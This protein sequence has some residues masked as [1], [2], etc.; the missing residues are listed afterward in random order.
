[1]DTK[2]RRRE[3]EMKGGE[4]KWTLFFLTSK[5]QSCSVGYDAI[6]VDSLETMTT[7]ITIVYTSSGQK[8]E[9]HNEDLDLRRSTILNILSVNKYTEYE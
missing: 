7:I 5:A 8:L 9:Y 6:N 4:W 1:M 3:G 2:E